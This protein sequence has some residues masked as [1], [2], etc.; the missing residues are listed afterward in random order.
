MR[1]IAT[2]VDRVR[3]LVR[4]SP[5]ICRPWL[6]AQRPTDP[7]FAH[8]TQM[9]LLASSRPWAWSAAIGMIPARLTRPTVGPMTRTVRDAAI[10]LGAVAGPD[11]R[12]PTTRNAK[13]K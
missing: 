8:R 2:P 4:R 10:L 6:W 12:D 13:A 5:R 1:S 11:P 7:L 9:E 3:D